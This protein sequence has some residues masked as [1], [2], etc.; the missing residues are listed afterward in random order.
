MDRFSRNRRLYDYLFSMGLY[1]D[2]VCVDG[3]PDKIDSIIVSTAPRK[4]NLLPADVGFPVEGT[5]VGDV[6]TSVGSDGDHVVDFPSLVGRPVS[7]HRE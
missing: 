6:V 4:V 5:E 1:V 7:I 2:A 3:N